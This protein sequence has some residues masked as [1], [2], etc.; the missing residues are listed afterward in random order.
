MDDEYKRMR[1]A[2]RRGMLEL[3]LVLGPFIEDGYARLDAAGRAA[4]RALMTRED[5]ELYAW[6]LRGVS[7]EDARLRDVV[8]AIR[9]SRD[10]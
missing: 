9:S 5:Q 2:S 7:P 1:W 10:P 8:D 3:D 6:L 4:Y